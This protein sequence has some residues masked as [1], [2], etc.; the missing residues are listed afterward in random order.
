MTG[1]KSVCFPLGVALSLVVQ[2]GASATVFDA[3]CPN[4]KCKVE[5]SR[6]GIS[7]NNGRTQIRNKDVSVWT[8]GGGKSESSPVSSTARGTVV[9]LLTG[10]AFLGP[11]GAVGG[12]LWGGASESAGQARPELSFSIEG[13][14]VEDEEVTLEIRFLSDASARR[15]RTQ[16]PMF[17]GLTAGQVRH[18]ANTV[19][20]EEKVLDSSPVSSKE[21]CTGQSLECKL[22]NT[23]NGL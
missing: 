21:R 18:K 5:L 9:G 14:S 1:F 8:A 7:I 19:S 17:T 6:N 20:G 15:F 2:L 3:L 16:L 12:A 22:S 4:A 10:A 23:A 13:T 11:V